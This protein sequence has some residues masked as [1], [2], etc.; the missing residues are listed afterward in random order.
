MKT[1]KLDTLSAQD[2]SKLLRCIVLDASGEKIGTMQGF[3]IDFSTHQ[4]AFIGVKSGSFSR[5]V[6]AVPARSAHIQEDGKAIVLE[7]SKDVISNAPSFN[8]KGDFAEVEKESVNAY[9]AR[10]VPLHRV[11]SIEEMRP[12]EA[13]RPGDKN[14]VPSTEHEFEGGEENRTTLERRD[15]AFFSEKGF[16]TDAMGEVNASQE[17]MRVLKEAKIRYQED[18]TNNSSAD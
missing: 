3:W 9:Y 13:I 14:D 8:P 17:L 11:S 2:A 6:R 15:Q 18:Q 4:I 1:R 5:N 7:Y 12:E 10:T 16:V